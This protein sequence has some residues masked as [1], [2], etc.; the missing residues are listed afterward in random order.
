VLWQENQSLLA[1]VVELQTL[2]ETLTGEVQAFKNKLVLDSSN[3]SKPPSTD[4]P[5]KPRSQRTKTGKTTGGQKGHRGHNLKMVAKPDHSIHHPISGVCSC[6]LLLSEATVIA[7]ERR[8]VYDLPVAKLEVTEHVLERVLCACGRKHRSNAPVDVNS[9]VQYG[10]RV[11]AFSVYCVVQQLI[12]HKRTTD[13]LYDLYDASISEGTLSNHIKLAYE[14]LEPV[15]EKIRL[16]IIK[17]PSVHV[18]ETGTKVSVAAC[19]P[20]STINQDGI[21]TEQQPEAVQGK[22]SNHWMHVACTDKLTHYHVHKNRGLEGAIA[23]GIINK[24]RGNLIHDC[25]GSYWKLNVTHGLCNAHLLRELKQAEEQDKV[26]W[27]V[28]MTKL[29]LKAYHGVLSSADGKLDIG[30]QTEYRQ[31][32]DQILEEAEKST[33]KTVVKEV[34]RGPVPQSKTYNLIKRM[35]KRANDILRFMYD[36]QVPFDNNQAERDLRMVK[37]KDKISGC[38]RGEGV[39]HFARIRG[40]LSTMNKQGQDLFEALVAVFSRQPIIPDF[41]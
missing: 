8:Q 4:P 18:D 3:S 7:P 34:K 30:L 13:M 12:P 14:L 9:A 6:G 1:R 11:R 41:C 37:L 10:P 38:A 39:K 28:Q 20:K 19:K 36:P 2:V 33:P 15:E 40:Y 16:G 29:I 21:A 27:P 23:G 31:Q 35:K 5:W 22:V 25:F 26:E 32:Y 17:S 24:Y